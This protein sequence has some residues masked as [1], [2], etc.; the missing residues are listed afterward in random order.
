MG[1][2]SGQCALPINPFVINATANPVES[3]G[4]S[5]KVFIWMVT[6]VRLLQQPMRATTLIN[7]TE[8]GEVV[9]TAASYSF[10]INGNRNLVANFAIVDHVVE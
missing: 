6:L 2:L 7:W 3:G 5:G 9:S 1:N 4:V 8:N 10:I